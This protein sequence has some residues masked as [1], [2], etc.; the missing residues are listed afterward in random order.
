VAGVSVGAST[1]LARISFAGQGRG[2]AQEPCLPPAGSNL[3][4]TVFASFCETPLLSCGKVDTD[5]VAISIVLAPKL[6]I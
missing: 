4:A 1:A 6:P 5:E 2:Q 3:L